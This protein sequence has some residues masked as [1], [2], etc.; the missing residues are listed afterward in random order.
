MANDFYVTDGT[1]DEQLIPDHIVHAV[2]QVKRL[3][4]LMRSQSLRVA[5]LLKLQR[6]LS[7]YLREID[8]WV[9][10]EVWST[11][12]DI[13]GSRFSCGELQFSPGAVPLV[14]PWDLFPALVRHVRGDWENCSSEQRAANERALEVGGEVRSHHTTSD[15]DRFCILTQLPHGHTDVFLD[16]E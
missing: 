1:H 4:T 8:E 6:E 11:G 9:S 5:E 15:D 16:R 7:D 3:S 13:P 2:E 10:T 14:P 12:H